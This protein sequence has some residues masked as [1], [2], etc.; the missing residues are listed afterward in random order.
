VTGVTF[1]RS[2]AETH[3]RV[4]VPLLTSV[5]HDVISHVPA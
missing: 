1:A 4:L 5:G 2:D 3:G